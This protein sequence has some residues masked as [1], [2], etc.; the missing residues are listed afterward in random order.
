MSKTNDRF[1]KAYKF[2]RENEGG[3]S[4]DPDDAGGKTI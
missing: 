3:F 4:D 1:I 2:M